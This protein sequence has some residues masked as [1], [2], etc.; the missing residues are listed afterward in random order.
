[1]KSNPRFEELPKQKSAACAPLELSGTISREYRRRGLL[2]AAPA[3]LLAMATAGCTR[4]DPV[5]AAPP[6]PAASWTVKAENAKPG[7]TDWHLTNPAKDREIEGYASE[8]SVN[9]GEGISIYVNTAEPSYTMQFFRMGWY[10]GAGAREIMSP[11]VRKGIAQPIPSAANE[12][13]LVECDWTDPYVLHIPA[14]PDPTDWAS[15]VYLVKLTAGISGKQS[16]V[17]FVV[18]DDQRRSELLFQLTVTTDEAYNAWDGWSLYTEPR[19][20]KVSFNRP[21]QEGG[22]AGFFF[23]WEYNML[24]FLEREGYDVSYSTD[25]DTHERGPLLLEHKAFLSVGHDE[26]WSWQMRQNVRAAR[27][28][29]VSLGFF[30]ADTSNW[31]IR[32]QPSTVNGDPDRT[33][34]CFKSASLDPMAY[35]PATRNLTTT[36]FRAP[37]VDWPEEEL[38]GVM[39]EGWFRGPPQDL[40]V[41]DASSWIFQNT[42]IRDGTHLP[43]L[44]GYEC[45][46]MY[47]HHPS[48]DHRVAHSPFPGID[49]RTFYSD[50]TWYEAPSGST[51]VA[52]GTMSWSW[53]LDDFRWDHAVFTSPVVQQATR[54]IMKRFGVTDPAGISVPR[55]T[56]TLFWEPAPHWR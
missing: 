4:S 51:V 46:R 45:D 26:Y 42:G 55:T 25:V 2:V 56:Q 31:Q 5:T 44:L 41:T 20:F 47:G 32:F 33:I 39:Y 14:S 36:A 35:S 7:S 34:V 53:G 8:T 19:A 1:M 52:T 27:D 28:N 12:M 22:G 54:N 30:G 18:R 24:R 43:G 29:G 16:F 13:H 38:V 23:E 11:V 48:D 9:R 50:M 3:L 21:Y 37:P 10:G 17:I 49:G 6:T 40:V 15:G